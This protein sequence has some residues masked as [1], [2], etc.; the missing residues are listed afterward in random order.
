VKHT[1]A[2][3]IPDKELAFLLSLAA[4][5]I[6]RAEAGELIVGETLLHE[7][8]RRAERLTDEGLCWGPELVRRYQGARAVYTASFELSVG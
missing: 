3:A 5:A 1:Q 6:D 7:G 2:E 4:E 8:Q